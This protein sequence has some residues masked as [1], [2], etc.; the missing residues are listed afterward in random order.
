MTAYRDLHERFDR[1]Y[2]LK[3]SADMLEWDAQA[4]M[5]EGGGSLRAA[6]LGTLRLLAHEVLAAPDMADRLSEAEASPPEDEWER[7]NVV[8]MRR[9]RR[10]SG[11]RSPR[12]S[13]AVT[14]SSWFSS[15]GGS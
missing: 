8:A 15:S 14:Q 6:Q 4:M 9:A 7:A 1:Y 5:P 12:W 11:L 2:L 13:A 3:S 10:C